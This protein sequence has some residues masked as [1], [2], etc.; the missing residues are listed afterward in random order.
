MDIAGKKW[1][2][3]INKIEEFRMHTYENVVLYKEKKKRWDDR[4]HYSTWVWAESSSSLGQ[5]RLNHFPRKLKSRWSCLFEVVQ[6]M[7]HGALEL[8]DPENGGPSLVN[9]QTVQHYWDS[10][11]HHHKTSIELADAWRITLHRAMMLNQ[12]L[13]VRQPMVMFYPSCHDVN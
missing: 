5:S 12:V 9:G 2:F 13:H 7:K 4:P 1:M 10:D 8:W 6:T 11:I 3:Q